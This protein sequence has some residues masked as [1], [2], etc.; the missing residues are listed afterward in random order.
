MQTKVVSCVAALCIALPALAEPLAG[1]MGSAF[2]DGPPQRPDWQSS[3]LDLPA[4]TD[5]HRGETIRLTVTGPAENVVVRLRGD[6][7]SPTGASGVEGGRRAKPT[8]GV[9]DIKL[10]ADHPH[11]VQISVH[12][13][14]H[15]WDYELGAMNGPATLVSVERI[16]LP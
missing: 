11:V 13:G 10:A 6:G 4:P 3:W 5:F 15:A 12:G 2:G 16:P 9:L 1:R 8:N 7:A 14:Q